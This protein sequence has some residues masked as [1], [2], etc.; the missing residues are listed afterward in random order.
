MENK[1]KKE[2]SSPSEICM[3]IV[4]ALFL[5]SILLVVFLEGWN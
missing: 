5:A 1:T 2:L 3:I 4:F